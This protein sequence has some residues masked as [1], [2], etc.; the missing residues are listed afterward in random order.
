MF[1][2]D[3]F[4]TYELGSFRSG[5]RF[6]DRAKSMVAKIAKRCEGFDE[7]VVCPVGFQ[8]MSAAPMREPELAAERVVNVG[9]WSYDRPAH[10]RLVVV[11]RP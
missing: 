4:L 8:G 2:S 6:Q 9:E 7:Y 1:V 3:C 5:A 11:P 10:V